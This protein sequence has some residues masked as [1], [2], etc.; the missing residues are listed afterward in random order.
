MQQH[1]LSVTE[2]LSDRFLNWL[3]ENKLSFFSSLIF[4]LLAHAFVITNK[5]PNHDDVSYLF[6]K[7]ETIRSGRWGLELLRFVIPDYSMPWL[8]GIVSLLLLS[9][10][11][12]IIVRVFQLHSRLGII[13][14]SG[15]I[16]SFPSQIG[17]FCY[18]YTSSCYA[19]AFLLSVLAVREATKDGWKHWLLS[20]IL[21]VLMASVYQAYISI[22]ASLLVL[23]VMQELLQADRETATLPILKRGLR[24][25]AILLIGFEL[26]RYSINLSLAIIH[27]T[28]NQYSN[29]AQSMAPSFPEGILVAYRF[30]FFNLTS[31][32]NMIIVSKTSRLLHFFSLFLSAVGIVW[33]Q[34]RAKN[35]RASLLLVLCLIVLPLSICCLYIVFYWN[36][37]HTLVLYSFFALYVLAVLAVEAIPQ[38]TVKTARDLLYLAVAVIL[39]INI[40]FANRCYLKL[41]LEYE[42]AYSLATTLVTQIRSLPGYHPDD[43]VV[44]YPSGGAALHFAPEFGTQEEAEHD[45]MGIQVQLLTG[46]TEA[47]F[48]SRFIGAEMNIASHEQAMKEITDQDFDRMPVYPADGSVARVEDGLVFVKL[49][50]S[51]ES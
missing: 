16:I 27:S 8:H 12:C 31:R 4:G 30:F 23:L 26:Y 33:S 37:I 22:T 39:G 28:V 40:F 20:V 46:Y 38:P 10:S 50:P 29:E 21:I 47:D 32:Y 36:T 6:S 14:L 35:L 44:I 17:T 49:A 25:V 7:G 18:M 48:I 15:L 42:N 9:I 41:F 45:L 51:P 13:L 11:I 19:V 5:L 43:L 1:N 24:Y 2:R 3:W 34:I